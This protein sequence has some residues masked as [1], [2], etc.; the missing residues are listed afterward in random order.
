MIEALLI[1]NTALMVG[2]IVAIR[3][4]MKANREEMKANRY[5]A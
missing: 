2:V 1:V 5:A 4:E 3:S